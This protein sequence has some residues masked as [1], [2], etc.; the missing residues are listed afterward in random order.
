MAEKVFISYRRDD[1]R[2]QARDIHKAFCQVIPRDHVFM[3]VDTIPPG[4]NFRKILQGWVNQCE[5]LL[6]LIGPG[7]INARDPKTKRRRLDNPSDFVRVEIGEALARDIPV[8]PLL[9]DGTPMPNVDLLPDD[10][11]ELV[12]RQAELV[13]YRTF[14][15]DVERLIRK[16]GL[17]SAGLQKDAKGALPKRAKWDGAPAARYKQGI[18]LRRENPRERH[19]DLGPRDP[20]NILAAGDRDRKRLPELLPVRYARM[21]TSPFAF[22]RGAAAVMAQDLKHEPSAG[23]AVQACGDCQLMNFGAFTAPDEEGLLFEI[24]D[25]D[26][27]LP[28]VDFTVDLKRLAASVALAALAHNFSNKRA[29]AA[30]AT[31]VTA[32]RLH[33]EALAKLSP[34]EIWHSRIDLTHERKK[35]RAIANRAIIPDNFPKVVRGTIADNPQI[36]HREGFDF[37]KFFASYK[38]SL[39]QGSRRVFEQYSL[40]DSASYADGVGSVGTFRAI[41]LFTSREG[42]PLFLQVKEAGRSVLE[43]L[44]SKFDGNP[45]QRVADGQRILQAANDIFLGWGKSVSGRYFYVR[46]LPRRIGSLDKFIEENALEDY[47]CLSGKTLACAHARS[48]D[49]AVIAGYIGEDEALDDALSYFALAY[50]KRTHQDFD[51]VRRDIKRL[52]RITV[53]QSGAGTAERNKSLI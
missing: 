19:A 5:V 16:L 33:M 38:K 46:Q 21:L 7:W 12:D 32:Y 30:V 34:L 31:T 14:D 42:A 49:P 37:G 52:G 45:G 43:C 15:T 50:A 24:V 3:D 41:S 25:F 44:G 39:T 47:A 48:A 1:S 8:V 20:V 2:Y 28:G 27:T 40:R 36:S 53:A 35:L 51:L 13:E 18:I 26:E 4:A 29:R 9:I 22:F 23:I 11:K 17:G 6:A 10:L